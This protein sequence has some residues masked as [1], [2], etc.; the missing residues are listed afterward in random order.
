MVRQKAVSLGRQTS[1]DAVIDMESRNHSF[2]LFTDST[3]G[4]DCVVYRQ[5][6]TGGYRV[7]SAGGGSQ[8]YEAGPLL[9]VSSTTTPECGV[10]A[11]VERVRITGL[12]FVFFVD[13]ATG[14]GC[15]LYR[16]GDGHCGL[17]SPAR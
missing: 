10:D 12:A 9:S 3:S 8:Q 16:R 4:A 7:A 17:I 2:W 13:S 1:E 11:A 6:P 5:G 14:R 15:V